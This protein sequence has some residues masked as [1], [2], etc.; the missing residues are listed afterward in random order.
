MKY[1][2]AAFALL[3]IVL[4]ALSLYFVLMNQ[5]ALA[6]TVWIIALGPACVVML[7]M[8]KGKLQVYWWAACIFAVNVYS[9]SAASFLWYFRP[10]GAV[11]G[12]TEGFFNLVIPV[13]FFLGCGLNLYALVS[14]LR[15]SQ[16]AKVDPI[17]LADS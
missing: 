14:L 11:S 1:K 17:M 13:G 6:A 10:L 3:F 7:Y 8:S 12:M 4:S 15:Q 5:Q 9:V 2:A 16:H